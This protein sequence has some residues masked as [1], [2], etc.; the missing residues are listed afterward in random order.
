MRETFALDFGGGKE[1]RF[2]V[3]RGWLERLRGLL[4]SGEEASPVVL[5]GCSSIHT[6]G[7]R[8][9]I[10]VALVNRQ[11]EVCKA[12]R[13]VRP[14][15]VVT[16]RRAWLAFERPASRDPWMSEGGVV[17]PLLGGGHARGRAGR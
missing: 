13:R 8:Y 11:G 9:P 2:R 10:D 17:L 4:A 3:L 14:G 16:A 1:I 12:R 6:F 15:R 5:V 7:M